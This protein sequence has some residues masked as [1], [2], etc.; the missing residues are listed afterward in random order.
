[1]SNA[2]QEQ[3]C[4]SSLYQNLTRAGAT[5][6]QRGNTALPSPFCFLNP[7]G[8]CYNSWGHLA[9]FYSRSV[10]LLFVCSVST[11]CLRQRRGWEGTKPTNQLTNP[12]EQKPK[13]KQSNTKPNQPNP[14]KQKPKPK[15]SKKPKSNSTKTPNLTKQTKPQNKT[16]T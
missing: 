7:I 16:Q 14:H 3:A 1:M 9:E 13:A 15:Q 5:G 12:H 8:S 10:L 2:E 6:A 11:G 4:L